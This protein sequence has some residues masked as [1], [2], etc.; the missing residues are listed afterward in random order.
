MQTATAINTGSANYLLNPPFI[1]LW[2]DVTF[3]GPE[4]S[5]SN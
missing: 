2:I 1:R 5:Y 4:N 3:R